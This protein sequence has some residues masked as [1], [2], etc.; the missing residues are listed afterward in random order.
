MYNHSHTSIFTF[1]NISG[2]WLLCLKKTTTK[3]KNKKQK[4]KTNN[5]KKNSN[6][7]N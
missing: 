2:V 6:N 3:N 7:H 4:Q 5:K 1:F